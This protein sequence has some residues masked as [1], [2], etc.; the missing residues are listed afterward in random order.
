MLRTPDALAAL[1][2]EQLAWLL[3]AIEGRA[4]V[5]EDERQWLY[6]EAMRRRWERRPPSP[7][8]TKRPWWWWWPGTGG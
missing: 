1:T 8:T 5:D 7:P 2:D 4:D 3:Q 6:A